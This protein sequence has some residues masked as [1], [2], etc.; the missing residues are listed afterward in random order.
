MYVNKPAEKQYFIAVVPS[1]EI[2]EEVT[3]FKHYIAENFQSKH[4]LKSPPHITL[5]M[6]FKWKEEKEKQLIGFLENFSSG[7]P[8]FEVR[9][10]NF[11][12]FPKRVIYID[13]VKNEQLEKLY[14]QLSVAIR[15]EL[16][17]VKDSYKNEGFTPHM[18]IAH[19]DLKPAAFGKAWP[20]FMDKEFERNFLV[21]HI[22]LLKHNGM[23]WEIFR[24]F[25]FV[26]N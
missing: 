1:E 9:L 22:C 16:K 14:H 18:T 24:R 20:E 25:I 13:I 6:P 11:S 17:I 23:N 8:A 19:R 5:H 21:N 4:S 10:K 26:N 12:A 15:K 2:S 7:Q 3:G